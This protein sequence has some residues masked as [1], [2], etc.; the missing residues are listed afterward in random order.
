MYFTLDASGMISN[1]NAL[2][3]SQLGYRI[4]ELTGRSVLVV[5][6]ENAHATVRAQLALCLHELNRVHAWEAEKVRKDG[7]LIWVRETAIGVCLQQGQPSV[8]IMCEDITE[9]KEAE[10]KIHHL[11]YFDPLTNLPNRRL[12]TDRLGHALAAG[13]RNDEYAALMM[14]DL[15]N[16]K[17]LNDTQGHDVGDRLLVEVASRLRATVREEDSVARLGGDEYV[18]LVED[19][20]TDETAAANQAEIVAEKIRVAL[21][22][23]LRHLCLRSAL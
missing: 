13:K 15:D 2:G 17:T 19:L 4:E 8:L 14:L 12:F 23:T 3:A 9:H 16:F 21:H 10:G 1:V 7:S 20:G 5:F 18:V 11:A 22:A 6:P